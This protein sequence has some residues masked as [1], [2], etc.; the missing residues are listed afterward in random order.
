LKRRNAIDS[1]TA[2][3]S[4]RKKSIISLF[5]AALLVVGTMTAFYPSSFTPK[6]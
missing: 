2:I 6:A 4:T 5:L 3:T 1:T